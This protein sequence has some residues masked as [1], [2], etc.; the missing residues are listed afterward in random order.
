MAKDFVPV[1]LRTQFSGIPDI[2]TTMPGAPPSRAHT[3]ICLPLFD[4]LLLLLLQ[5]ARV[6]AFFC[7][8]VV[9]DLVTRMI[10]ER[11]F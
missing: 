7:F 8:Q 11:L 6:K 1:N 5:A 10:K 9:F 4:V 2:P 3:H